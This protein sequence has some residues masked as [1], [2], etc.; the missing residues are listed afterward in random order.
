MTRQHLRATVNRL[1]DPVL[2]PALIVLCL[3]PLTRAVLALFGIAGSL[4]A[5]PVEELLNR[6]GIWGLNLLLLTLAVTPVRELTGAQALGRLRRTLGLYAFAYVCLHLT[7]Y[8][9]LD[10]ALELGTIAQDIIKRPYITIG[11]LAFT[12]LLPLA[13]TS[14][15]GMRRRLGRWWRRLHWLIYPIAL[16]GVTHYLWQVKQDLRNPLLYAGALALLL[17]YRVW[18]RLRR[19]HGGVATRAPSGR[20]SPA[21]QRSTPLPG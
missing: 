7:V 21:R 12:A 14:T 3:V 15:N 20:R 2:Q 18:R 4:G 1:V 19:R 16:L 17:A 5:N 10:R 11:M 8:I 9:T 13:V 6:A